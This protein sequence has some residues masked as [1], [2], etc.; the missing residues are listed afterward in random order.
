MKL[1][2][3]RSKNEYKKI[4]N[5]D[6]HFHFKELKKI[7]PDTDTDFTIDGFSLPAKKQVKFH[8]DFKYGT[9]PDVNWRERVVCPE[10]N[11]NNRLRYSDMIIDMIGN[12]Y[13]EDKIYIM[14]QVTYFYTYLKSKHN[15]L[16]GSEFIGSEFNSGYINDNGILHQDAT[17]LSFNNQEFKIVLSFEV[18]EH[19]PDYQKAL[20]E[21]Q[22]VL[23]NGAK[24]I[25]SA[26]FNVN[27]N[28]T[29]VRAKVNSKGKIIHILE[30]EYHGD[31][32][33]SSSEGVLCFQH[34]GWDIL[35]VLKQVG[36]KDAYAIMGWSLELGIVTPQII[37]VAEK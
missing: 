4:L 2:Y 22:R 34:F 23:R 3:I 1:Y 21:C 27:S 7:V 19:I 16:V 18:L 25:F 6:L 32:M 31:P 26:P 24:L 37:I 29:I 12:V 35:S 9:Y 13:S 30:P 28:E 10:T 33:N 11:L 36:F 17:N 8:V 5:E 20:F 15:N 14:E